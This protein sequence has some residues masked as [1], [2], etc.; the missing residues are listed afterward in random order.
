MVHEVLNFDN[1][2]VMSQLSI[3]NGLKTTRGPLVEVGKII[4]ER[5]YFHPIPT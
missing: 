4:C 2:S 3:K 1:Q 5:C